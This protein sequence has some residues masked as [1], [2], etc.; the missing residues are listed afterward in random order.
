[1]TLG[2]FSFRR[3]VVFLGSILSLLIAPGC[4]SGGGGEGAP[5]TRFEGMIVDTS[6]QGVADVEVYLF[7]T[8]ESTLSDEA[9]G[10]LLESYK[11]LS[12]ASLYFRAGKFTNRIQL[13][14]FPLGTLV[15]RPRMVLNRDTDSV[16]ILEVSFS[17]DDTPPEPTPV[18]GQPPSAEA[19]PT[20]KP[21][22]DSNGNTTAFG[23]P[24]GLRGNVG[25]GRNVWSSV[26]ASCHAT[27]KKN[28][29]Y[30]QTKAA[31]RT[32]PTMRA[33]NLSNQQVADVTAYLNRSRK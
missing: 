33:L 22:F 20:P 11:H 23:I 8:N 4:G 29:T 7:E 6:G 25:D 31:L 2:L 10:F 1:M 5:A 30:G 12:N 26:C 14:D 21:L 18:P 24:N 27:E 17:S 9:G 13:G 28:R 19:T 3:C 32:E 15:V 16:E